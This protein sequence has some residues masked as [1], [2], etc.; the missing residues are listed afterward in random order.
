[1]FVVWLMQ[2]LWGYIDRVL[3][4]MLYLHIQLVCN[5]LESRNMWCLVRNHR[6]KSKLKKCFFSTL[7]KIFLQQNK[8]KFPKNNQFFHRNKK[9][10]QV[11]EYVESVYG[12]WYVFE[13]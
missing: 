4:D 10:L 5:K 6:L 8:L 3:M 9:N 13:G 1:M 12:G 2:L 7:V 11:D